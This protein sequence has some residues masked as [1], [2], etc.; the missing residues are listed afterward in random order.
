V[1]NRQRLEL[2]EGRREEFLVDLVKALGGWPRGSVKLQLIGTDLDQ[3]VPL[4]RQ[5]G[6]RCQY[7]FNV[8]GDESDLIDAR[9]E[10]IKGGLFIDVANPPPQGLI[11]VEVGYGNRQ[12]SSIFES[13]ESH[14][15]RLIG[16]QV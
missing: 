12:W 9:I 1:G 13:M 3:L 16:G 11:Q 10:P 15:I 6:F 8:E 7:R 14:N 5:P 2:G 4:L